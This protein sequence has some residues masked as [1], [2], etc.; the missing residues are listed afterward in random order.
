MT[1]KFTWLMRKRSLIIAVATVVA[2]VVGHGGFLQSGLD[3]RV[4][5]AQNPSTSSLIG[6]SNDATLIWTDLA[7]C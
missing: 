6:Y 4:T 2:V 3:A 7:E 5:Q 1:S